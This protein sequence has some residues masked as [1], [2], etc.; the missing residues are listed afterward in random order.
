MYSRKALPWP[1][2][3]WIIASHPE[4]SGVP[5]FGLK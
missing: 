4:A 5:S 1:G 3:G 2:P